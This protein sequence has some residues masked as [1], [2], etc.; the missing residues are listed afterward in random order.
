MTRRAQDLVFTLFGDYLLHRRGPVWVGSLLALLATLGTKPETSR[1]VLSRMVQR[2]WLGRRRRGRRSDYDLTSRGRRLLE[3]GEQRIHHPPRDEPWTGT[4]YLVTYSVPEE[5]RSQRD[6]MRTRLSWLGCGSLGNGLWITPH[7]VREQ[8]AA[9]ARE[10]DVRDHIEVFEGRH[11][12]YS[13]TSELVSQCWDLTTVA[14]RYRAFLARNG[15]E[16]V[17]CRDQLE[18]GGLTPRQCFRRRFRLIHEY[19]RFPLVDP[20]LPRE[21][22]P[23]DWP[24]EAAAVL[25]R[26]YHALLAGPSEE[27]VASVL[28]ADTVDSV[29]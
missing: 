4:W 7:D 18:A 24:G 1:T 23:A 29:S 13:S 21:L 2:G 15:P 6:R 12:G 26:D 20:Y 5:R 9:M 28:A 27:Y 19:R 22:L 25:F 14:A 10:L 3:E 16:Y 17:R 11:I 8:V